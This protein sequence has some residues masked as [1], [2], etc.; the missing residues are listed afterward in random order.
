V[1]LE[2]KQ[3]SFA[4]HYRNCEDP[5]VGPWLLEM[6][7]PIA[8]STATKLLEGK[9]VIEVAPRGLPDKGL[10][11]LQLVRERDLQGVV[12]VGDDLADASAFREIR[13][14]RDATGIPGLA[15][16]VVDDETPPLVRASAD[17][18]IDGV[19]DVERFLRLLADSLD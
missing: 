19:D 11:L 2:R 8:E 14:R 4:L 9:Q 5:R 7:R 6:L 16:A 10:A 3:V 18:A 1:E 13:R 12:F 15:I 17:L